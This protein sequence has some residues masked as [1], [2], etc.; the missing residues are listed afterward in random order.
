MAGEPETAE[1]AGIGLDV[2]AYTNT[3][4]LTKVLGGRI[5][6][7]AEL[8][9]GNIVVISPSADAYGLI[10]AGSVRLFDRVT[11]LQIG[12]TL[13][14]DHSFDR[15]GSHG[16]EVLEN[17]NFVVVAPFDSVN[18]LVGA[19]SVMLIDGATGEQIGTTLAGDQDYD[20]LGAGGV[21]AL[22]NGNFV[23]VSPWDDAGEIVDAG[24]LILVH[25]ATGE[26]IGS[27]ELGAFSETYLSGAR[28]IALANGNFVFFL[29]WKNY[30]GGEVSPS[31]AMLIDGMTLDQIGST[32]KHDVTGDFRD[33]QITPLY[34][35]NFV[36]A[37]PVDDANDLVR[38]G[39]VML[40]DGI[41]GRQLGETISGDQAF[42]SF[43]S[44]G[45]YELTNG[46]FVVATLSD[47]EVGIV[48]AG[49]VVVVNGTT[50]AQVGIAGENFFAHH[51]A[52]HRPF[53]FDVQSVDHFS[54]ESFPRGLAIVE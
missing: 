10:E 48:D 14:G 9:N 31:V 33:A 50:G 6:G 36:L 32:L 3:D 11:G 35:G 18:N 4:T 24:S 53:I 54:L 8:P 52:G 13:A 5:I 39:S 22:R 43:G 40:F 30:G 49:S 38:S 37:L 42:D 19:G 51:Q 17:G 16:F 26:K 46:Y 1:F 27:T 12:N 23:V 25:G 47:D 21:E 7:P 45:V 44:G 15:L 2:V 29:P 28:A 34:N 20:Y 41:T